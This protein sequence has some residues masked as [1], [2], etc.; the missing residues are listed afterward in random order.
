MIEV[1]IRITKKLLKNYARY[2]REIPMLERELHEMNTSEAGLGSSTIFDYSTG[3]PRP[4][5]VVGFDWELYQR[6]QTVLANK[7]AKTAAV[8][9]WIEGI[10]D[11]QT[12]T[13][14]KMRYIEGQSWT[15]I[16]RNIGYSGR[17]DYVRIMIRDQYL[18]KCE[19]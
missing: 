10:E 14:F 13:V 7:K 5:A 18:K 3:Y 15:Q 8:E 2:K 19:I 16:A 4:Q 6:R 1:G 11:I 17:E 9:Q 12:R